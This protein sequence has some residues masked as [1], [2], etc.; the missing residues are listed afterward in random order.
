MSN[1]RSA[2]GDRCGTSR[3]IVAPSLSIALVVG[4]EHAHQMTTAHSTERGNIA[5]PIYIQVR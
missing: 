4:G 5:T 3:Q 1:G 2:Q